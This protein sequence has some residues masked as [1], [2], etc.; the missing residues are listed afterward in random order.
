MTGVPQCLIKPGRALEEPEERE[1][2]TVKP[3]GPLTEEPEAAE[4]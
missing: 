2:H 1:A 4:S 3:E